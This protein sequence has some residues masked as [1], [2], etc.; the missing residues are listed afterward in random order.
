ML[1]I[2][3]HNIW[4]MCRDKLAPQF[5]AVTVDCVSHLHTNALILQSLLLVFKL[6]VSDIASNLF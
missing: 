4:G 1:L 6:L 2:S 5:G 3:C